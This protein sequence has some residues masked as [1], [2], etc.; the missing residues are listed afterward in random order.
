MNALLIRFLFSFFRVDRFGIL[1]STETQK[2]VFVDIPLS[3]F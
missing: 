2:T 1:A 3:S